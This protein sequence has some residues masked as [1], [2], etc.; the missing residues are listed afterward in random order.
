MSFLNPTL[1]WGLALI[2]LPV[3]IHLINMLRHRRV[4]WAAME[5][6][7]ASQ[8]RNSTWVRLKELLLLLVRMAAVAAVVL[9]VAQ[10]LLNSEFGRRF[11]GGATHHIVL[12]DDSFSMDDR[13]ADTSALE[14]AKTA[15]ERIGRQAALESTEQQFTLLRLSRSGALGPP[16]P[17]LT[18]ELVDES[19][20]ERLSELLR[21]MRPTELAVGPEQGLAAIRSLLPDE[22]GQRRVLYLVTDFRAR[23]WDEPGELRTALAA[24]DE[25]GYELRLINAVDA[26]RGNVAITQL[27]PQAGTRAAGVPLAMELTVH[28]FGDTAVRGVSVEIDQDGEP[29]SGLVIDEI[30][31]RES[32]TRRFPVYFETAGDHL[33]TARLPS[34]TVAADNQRFSLVSVPLSVPVLLVDGGADQA[35]A[36]FLATALAP[37]G[38][39]TTGIAPR[40]ETPS[41]LNNNPLEGFQAIYL[42]DIE[43]LDAPAIEALEAYVAAGGGLGVF[44]GPNCRT[45]FFNEALHREGAGLMPLPLVTE[46]QL[47]VD[48]LDK[49]ADMEV[50]DHPIFR[51]F[52][53]ERN[54]FLAGVGIERY[55]A[56]PKD[57]APPPES[58]VRVL[59]RLRNGAPLAVERRFGSGRVV[60]FLSTAAPVWNNW[61]RNPSFVVAMLEMQSYLAPAPG[62]VGQTS[63]VGEPI[64]LQLDATKYQ[65]RVRMQPPG[66]DPSQAV[67]VELPPPAAD[68]SLAPVAFEETLASGVYEVQLSTIE[69]QPEQRRWALN[70]DPDEGDLRRLDSRDLATRLEGIDYEY[71]QAA[72]YQATRPELAGSN[73]SQWI[74]LLLVALLV[75]EQL[76]AYVVSYHPPAAE[77]RS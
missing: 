33:L 61:G 51:I 52:L 35:N 28:N 1:L 30:G 59:A 63:L 39:V 47:L 19:F 26:A 40:I 71:R 32:Q 3:L 67:V 46:T 76:L 58:T 62:E 24:L 66:G 16:R 7:L 77:A 55:F 56:A 41:Y 8:K 44:M 12:L 50:T 38:S 43:R 60:A 73:I 48:R 2:A 37:R 74:L 15:I 25:A 75:G 27:R 22:Q 49:G 54:S 45:T 13:W 20:G 72:D 68:G 36:R 23:Q 34:D 53:G 31:P 29:R 17:D 42:L 11:G 9:I 65:S 18:E 10:P 69:N 4:Q 21:P 70:V 64:E 5:F 14:Q 6:L 57:W